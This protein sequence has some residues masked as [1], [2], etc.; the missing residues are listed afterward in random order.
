MILGGEARETGYPG[1]IV[2]EAPRRPL[3]PEKFPKMAFISRITVPLHCLQPPTRDG[4][5]EALR[6]A[7]RRARVIYALRGET[8]QAW[9]REIVESLVKADR[10]SQ[11]V[12]ALEGL[13]RVLMVSWGPRRSCG[14]GCLLVAPHP[15]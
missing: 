5:L 10:R 7:P 1:V 13:D 4:L 8:K 11:Y 12:L 2:I 14:Y 6:G 15:L 3:P 9:I